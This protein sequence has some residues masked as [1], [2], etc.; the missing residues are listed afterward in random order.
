[1]FIETLVA[2]KI[3]DYQ[4]LII[5]HCG[6]FVNVCGTISFVT[7]HGFCIVTKRGVLLRLL[8]WCVTKEKLAVALVE[9]GFCLCMLLYCYIVTWF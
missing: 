8:R 6:T 4:Y 5:S 1:L 2:K 9:R 3:L 7:K